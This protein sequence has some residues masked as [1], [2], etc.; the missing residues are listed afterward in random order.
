MIQDRETYRILIVEDNPGDYLLVE[1]FL[2]EYIQHPHLKHVTK[3]KQAQSLLEE[4]NKRFDIIL[5]DLSLP[6]IN[7]EKLIE[8]TRI[9]T[10]TTP[11][12]ILTGYSDLDFGAKS[13]SKGVSDYLIKDTINALVL[14]KSILYAIERHRF[15]KSLRE[16]EKRYMDL[17]HLSPAPILVYDLATLRFIDVNEAAVQHYGYSKE[18]FLSMT[19][20]GIRPAEEIPKMEEA[21]E[22]AKEKSERYFTSG[23]K[24]R[25]KNG[26]VIDVEL[27]SN[28]IVFDGKQA[29]IVLATDITEKLMQ[30]KAI[31][32]QNERLKKITWTQ[33]HVVRAPV[34]RL[35][36]LVDLLKS[37]N[38]DS[39]EKDQLL[40]HIYASA[41]ELDEVIHQIVDESQSV[42]N[43][44][45]KQNELKNSNR[46]R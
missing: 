30:I 19:L 32:A 36:G 6:D 24:H 45:I 41:K 28:P 17:F 37:E 11:V 20:H 9:I 4:D 46:R 39:N 27:A 33:S 1:D 38:V 23:Y 3:F 43:T 5:L 22:R 26:E 14:Y 2:S 7:K 18:E 8:E 42:M 44:S 34:A 13:L 31:E 21:V 29:E 40:Q 25:K 15:L 10:Q 16:S 12:V 35:M